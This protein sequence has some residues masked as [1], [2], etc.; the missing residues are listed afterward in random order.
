MP[1]LR[2]KQRQFLRAVLPCVIDA[3]H[4][5][6]MPS[7]HENTNESAEASNGGTTN[8][9]QPC[10][11]VTAQTEVLE[12]NGNG[13]DSGVDTGTADEKQAMCSNCKNRGHTQQQTTCQMPLAQKRSNAQHLVDFNAERKWTL[14][15]ATVLNRANAGSSY[16]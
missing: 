1:C 16:T 5:D 10:T 9:N 8:D 6:P 2:A 13:M 3:L 12:S 15:R 11:N 4:D 14:R 7:L